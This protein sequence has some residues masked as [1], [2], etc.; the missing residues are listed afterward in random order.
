MAKIKGEA[1]PEGGRLEVV[2]HAFFLRKGEGEGADIHS[3]Y[4]FT[5][6]KGVVLA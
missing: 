4:P 1:S 6:L 3:G 5:R 2:E